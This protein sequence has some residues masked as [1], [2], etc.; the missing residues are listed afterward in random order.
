MSGMPQV[1]ASLSTPGKGGL[2]GKG[3]GGARRV[4]LARAALRLDG[5]FS[6]EAGRGAGADGDDD[7]PPTAEAG[8][9]LTF[10]LP[11]IST[12][13]S[14]AEKEEEEEQEVAAPAQSTHKHAPDATRTVE[15][16]SQ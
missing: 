15:K 14:G 11:D 10:P 3:V 5:L 1:C 4:S 8:R 6:A 13:G 9:A 12:D 7:L 16:E 2:A